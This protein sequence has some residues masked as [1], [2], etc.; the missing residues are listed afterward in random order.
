[1]SD[2]HQASGPLVWLVTIVVTTLLLIASAKA[3]WLVVPLLLAIILYYMLYPVVRRLA[4]AGVTRE[5][6]AA[7]VA[8]GVAVLAIAV[9]VPTVPWLL[10]QSVSGEEAL[11]RYLEGGRVLIDRTLTTLEAQFAFLQRMDFHAEVGRK[12]E[13]FGDA[14]MQKQLAE[15]LLRAAMGLP[16]L[17]LAPFFAFFLLRDGRQMLQMLYAAVPNAFFE[18]S[19]YMFDRV[20]MTARNYFQGLL[21][22]AAADTALLT[23]GLWIIG[24]PGA[25]ILGVI[26]AVLAWIP[27]VGAVLGGTMVVLAAATAFPADP[28]IVYASLALFVTVR[29][30]DAFVVMPLTVGR[31]IR[32]HPVPTVL[33]IFIGGTV[34]GIAGL[35]LALPLA[36]VVSTVVGTIGGIVVDPRLRARHA[37][38]KALEAQRMTS[39]LRL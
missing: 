10:A 3:L 11:N 34:A 21:K 1:M 2:P 8:G 4:L 6:A 14:F 17:L 33:M 36:A 18:R 20:H 38:A 7:L 16:S 30:L 24:V 26:A 39:D 25:F 32:M 31:S 37:Y 29:M 15:T 35:V 13:E 9:I 27:V 22:L 12:A 19:V 28:W 5:T 23:L